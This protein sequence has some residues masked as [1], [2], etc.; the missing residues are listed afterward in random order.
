MVQGASGPRWA[1]LQFWIF[2][3]VLTSSKSWKKQS[4]SI[5]SSILF[6]V[7]HTLTITFNFTRN[8]NYFEVFLSFERLLAI[9]GVV[10]MKGRCFEKAKR[11]PLNFPTHKS[12]RTRPH[13]ETFPSLFSFFF[14]LFF[15]AFPPS[16]LSPVSVSGSGYETD[17]IYDIQSE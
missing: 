13:T 14:F 6:T 3:I 17:I 9:F 8:I 15:F 4:M 5:F 7:N 11:F 12:K 16:R 1:P 10:L 2:R